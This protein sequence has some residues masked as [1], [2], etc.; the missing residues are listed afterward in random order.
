MK[1]SSRVFAPTSCG[2]C[3][4]LVSPRTDHVRALDHLCN[5]LAIPALPVADGR[6]H[7]RGGEGRRHQPEPEPAEGEEW[8]SLLRVSNLPLVSGALR[9]YEQ[10]K[11]SSRVVK[12]L[13]SRLCRSCLT[14][15]LHDLVSPTCADV[16]WP[17]ASPHIQYGA[18]RTESSMKSISRTVI[19]HLPVNRLDEFA[20]RQLDRV[21]ARST[22]FS[23]CPYA[24]APHI[25]CPFA[26]RCDAS[27]LARG[28]RCA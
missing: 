2:R 11:A 19:D 18:E 22:S 21:R 8:K 14:D 1:E 7:A 6:R 28:R 20:C 16:T 9:A 12:V 13:L 3:W 4:A 10:S 23:P 5:V 25:F 15:R 26:G 24:L 27:N 17:V